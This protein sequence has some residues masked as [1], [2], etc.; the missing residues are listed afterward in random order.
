VTGVEVVE[1]VEIFLVYLVKIVI[2]RLMMTSA[3]IIF[4]SPEGLGIK[5]FKVWTQY[6]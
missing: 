4:E 3:V 2:N 5:N 6:N 1:M